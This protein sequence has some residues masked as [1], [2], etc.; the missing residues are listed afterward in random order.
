[1]G[2]QLQLLSPWS[3]IYLN[4]NEIPVAPDGLV[5]IDTTPGQVL[6]FSDSQ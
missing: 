4:G 1:V 5:T 6:H 2:N 3:N